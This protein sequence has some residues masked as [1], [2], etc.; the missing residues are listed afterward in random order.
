M[1]LVQPDACGAGDPFED[2]RRLARVW[3]RSAYEA[4]L[5]VG[6]VVEAQF[7]ESGGH[8]FLSARRSTVRW[9]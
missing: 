9:R 4:A 1:L 8:C 6:I 2:Q 7:F 3:A 5:H